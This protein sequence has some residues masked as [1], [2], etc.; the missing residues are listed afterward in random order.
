MVVVQEQM[1]YGDAGTERDNA[2]GNRTTDAHAG[3]GGRRDDL[4]IHVRQR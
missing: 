2:C 3:V 4:L 1:I